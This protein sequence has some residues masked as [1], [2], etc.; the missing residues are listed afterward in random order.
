VKIDQKKVSIPAE[1]S[2]TG[3][4]PRFPASHILSVIGNNLNGSNKRMKTC[5]VPAIS[6]AKGSENFVYFDNLQITHERGPITEETH[7]Y[8]FGLVMKGISS[9]SLGFGDPDNNL[10][11]NGKE[12]QDK[13][14]TDGSGIEW[15]DY[16]GRMYDPQIGR[17]HVGDPMSE[18]DMNR[19]WDGKSNGI[20]QPAGAY[21]WMLQ[22]KDN[23]GNFHHQKGTVVL[24][25]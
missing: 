9:K 5:Y 17:W 12:K 11:Y 2:V 16:G 14:F 18:K 3:E 25:R 21:V 22:A 6:I 19:G 15:L 24:I 13:E 4:F 1:R 20:D 23:L 8:P 7:Y 10:E